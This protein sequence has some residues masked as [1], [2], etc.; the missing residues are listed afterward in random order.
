M[1]T[2]LSEVKGTRLTQVLFSSCTN[3]GIEDIE[4][5]ANI[6]RSKHLPARMKDIVSPATI[7]TYEA[8]VKHGRL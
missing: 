5:V 4:P 7:K 1:Y 2:S 6:V 3:S 8:A